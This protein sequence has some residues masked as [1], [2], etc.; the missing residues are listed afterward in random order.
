M[1]Y[2]NTILFFYF[3]FKLF[4]LYIKNF[5][6]IDKFISFLSTKILLLCGYKLN[7]IYFEN[8]PSKLIIIGSHT[9]IYDFIIG[10]LFYYAIMHEKYS[11]Y[12]FMKS[13]F[14]KMCKPILIFFDK[15]FKLISIDTDKTNNNIKNGITTQISDK[16]KNEDNYVIFIAPEGTRKCTENLRSGYWYIAKNLDINIAYLG[17][18]YS[19]KTIFMEEYRK[20][21]D[22]WDEEKEA[23]IES[24]IKY[25]P[26]YPERCYWTKKYYEYEYEYEDTNN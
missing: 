16:L 15:K 7:I 9:S 14:E 13:S 25:I 19:L 26:L 1:Y 2:F 5:N 10:V 4:H 11:T 3:I 6:N 17:I 21:F 8:L 22:T 12:V 23:F 18:D 24:C 20:P